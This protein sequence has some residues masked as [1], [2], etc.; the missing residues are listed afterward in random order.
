M[1]HL[2]GAMLISRCL[3]TKRTLDGLIMPRSWVTRLLQD[4]VQLGDMNTRRWSKYVACMGRL[5][6]DVY[7]GDNA[8]QYSLRS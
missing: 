3:K 4:I 2:C 1:D 6:G 5:L 8:G 7:T